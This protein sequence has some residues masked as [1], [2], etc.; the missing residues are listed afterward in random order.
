MRE[1]LHTS[2]AAAVQR[3]LQAAGDPGDPPEFSLEIPKDPD[4]GDFACNAA[5]LLAKRLRQSPRD[6][7]G[8]LLEEL[9]DGDGLVDR[10]EVAGPGFV[11]LWLFDS[12]WHDLLRRVLELGP[13]YGHSK[14]G[15]GTRVQVEF[16]SA[17]PTGPLTLGHGRQ[18][19]L[20]D[21]LARLLEASGYEVT[22]EYYFNNSGRQMRVLGDSVRARYLEQLGRAAAPPAQ[23][24]DAS[25]EEWPD[26]IDGLP[27]VFPRDGYRGD[28]IEDLAQE[29]RK[30][31]GDALADS[32]QPDGPENIFRKIAEETIFAEIRV[33][34]DKLG[35]VFDVYSNEMDLYTEGKI[36]ETLNELRAKNLVY[37]KDDAVWLRSTEFGLD[38]DRVLVKRTGE[39]TYLLPDIAYHREK[40]RRGFDRVIDVQGADHLEQFQYVRHAAGALGCPIDGMELVMHQFVTLSRSGKQVKQSTR[41]ATYITVD[42]LMGDVGRDVFRFF[43]VQRKADGHLDFDLDLAEST[44]WNKNPVL[45][46]QY[47]HARTHGLERIAVQ[48]GV[49]MPTATDVDASALTLP[50]EIEILKKIAEFPDVV[51]NAAEAREPHHVAYYALELAGLWNPYV[52]DRTRHRILSD[53]PA[54]TSGRLG[55][56]LAVRTVLANALSLLGLSAPER[57]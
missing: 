15:D 19:I 1:A 13:R 7:A 34:L 45:K 22:R 41:R 11:N 8:R 52:Q 23:A 26:E 44:E 21:A 39:P 25:E 14:T 42:E 28:Y 40:F 24:F 20:G 30:Q 57:M 35:I 51:R 53:D 47:A 27:V 10:G 46:I 49:P 43:M 6:I 16:V 36:E 2:I 56:T 50:E 31:H 48:E 9:G 5:M 55:L 32:D 54:I 4:H 37:D 38:R 12:R 33:S 17:N 3:L 29:L 18:A